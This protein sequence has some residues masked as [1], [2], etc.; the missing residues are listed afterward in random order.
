MY[1]GTT[2]PRSHVEMWSGEAGSLMARL[3]A[4]TSCL[5]LWERYWMF[6][7]CKSYVMRFSLLVP[8]VSIHV[9]NMAYMYP[10]FPSTS[11]CQYHSFEAQDWRDAELCVSHAS[12]LS[13]RLQPTS[14]T[15]PFPSC[16]LVPTCIS[17]SINNTRMWLFGWKDMLW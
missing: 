6:D 3:Q 8:R 7:T 14:S 9:A 13:E 16:K 12:S 5:A 2:Q 4:Q 11:S 1:I 17:T 10:I 15:A